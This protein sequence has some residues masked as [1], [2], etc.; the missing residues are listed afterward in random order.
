MGTY[1]PFT[2]EEKE[3]AASVDLEEFLRQ[4]G[5]KLLPSGREKRLASDRSITI[6]GSLEEMLLPLISPFW[7]MESRWHGRDW[8]PDGRIWPSLSSLRRQAALISF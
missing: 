3:R 2:A 8:L 5:E 7:G 4:R 1:I 6:C